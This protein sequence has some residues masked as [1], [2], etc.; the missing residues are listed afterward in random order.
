MCYHS[1]SESDFATKKQ[2]NI[3]YI[4]LSSINTTNLKIYVT[5]SL[6]SMYSSCL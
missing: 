6:L 4:I 5:V 2:N 3:F 1:V